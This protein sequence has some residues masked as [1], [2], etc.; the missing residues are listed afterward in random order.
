MVLIM[1]MEEVKWLNVVNM[2]SLPSTAYSITISEIGIETPPSKVAW[3]SKQHTNCSLHFQ[4]FDGLPKLFLALLFWC[5][6]R[7]MLKAGCRNCVVYGVSI[8]GLAN[9]STKV[10]LFHGKFLGLFLLSSVGAAALWE[11]NCIFCWWAITRHPFSNYCDGSE[12]D[13]YPSTS[14]EKGW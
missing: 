9:V 4:N 1:I 7:K 6:W 11:P 14:E 10:W 13:Q 12:S 3:L 2:L 8:T 5:I